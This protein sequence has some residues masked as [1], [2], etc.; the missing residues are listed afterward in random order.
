MLGLQ[1]LSHSELGFLESSRQLQLQLQQTV[2]H[3]LFM[4]GYLAYIKQINWALEN[5]SFTKLI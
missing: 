3:H 1:V 2:L 4:E 5:F